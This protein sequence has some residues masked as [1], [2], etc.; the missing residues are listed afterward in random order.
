MFIHIHLIFL[1]SPFVSKSYLPDVQK[2][3]QTQAVTH[4]LMQ[5]AALNAFIFP[6]SPVTLLVASCFKS[7]S[8]V[9]NIPGTWSIL[10]PFFF[11]LVHG[12]HVVP[13]TQAIVTCKQ[14]RGKN[15]CDFKQ[16]VEETLFPVLSLITVSNLLVLLLRFFLWTSHRGY[17]E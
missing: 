12:F 11:N 8:S 14:K 7:K 1:I 5:G 4:T 15:T 9:Q 6:L 13:L 17:S 3:M 16:P 2:W 10:T